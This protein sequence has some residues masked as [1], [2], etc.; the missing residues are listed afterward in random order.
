M[1]QAKGSGESHSV[2][3]AITMSTAWAN[4]TKLNDAHAKRREAA[5]LSQPFRAYDTSAS[6]AAPTRFLSIGTK[7]IANNA[8]A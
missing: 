8:K 6:T 1:C 5:N 3:K 4:R 2:W 7:L